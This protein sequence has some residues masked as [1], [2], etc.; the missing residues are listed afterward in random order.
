MFKNIL[1]TMYLL[2]KINK[3][4]KKKAIQKWIEKGV[5]ILIILLNKVSLTLKSL[6]FKSIYL[7]IRD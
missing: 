5:K 1:D 3:T 7:N 6:I 2:I 4:N